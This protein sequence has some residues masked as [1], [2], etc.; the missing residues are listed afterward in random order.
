[1]KKLAAMLIG[2]AALAA[3]WSGTALASWQQ[4]TNGWWYQYADGS[5]PAAGLAGIEG[6]TYYFDANGYMQTGWQ[7]ISYK[8]Y[9]FDGDGSQAFG[10]RQLDG[11]WYYL[12]SYAGGQ[13]KTG[14]MDINGQRYHFDQNGVMSVG[15]F[16]PEDGENGAGYAYQT[17][18]SGALIRNTTL[19]QGS[20][21]VKYD[22]YG[23]ITFRN[24][25]TEE[26]HERYGTDIWQPLLS[27]DQLDE[28]ADKEETLVREIQNDMW[29]YYEDEVKKAP[30]AER[31]EA[32]EQWKDDVRDELRDLMSSSDI[33]AFIRKVTGEGQEG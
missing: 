15:I 25:K 30:K 22:A 20:S 18:G 31:A 7:Y 5:F 26:D 24:S 2:A 16:F 14:W 29:D 6:K 3:L 8:W 12:D 21:K 10:W 33:E 27:Q 23:R 9:Y 4:D 17:D 13:M 19:R 32:L 28:T 11:K 1:M